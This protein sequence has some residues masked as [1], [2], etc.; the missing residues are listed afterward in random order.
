MHDKASVRA[1]THGQPVW[2]GV[3]HGQKFEVEGTDTAT[4]A[5]GDFDDR[6]MLAVL[7]KFGPDERQGQL[8]RDDGDV[9]AFFQQVRHGA[10]VVFVAV[11]QHDAF[12]VLQAITQ[13][14]EVRQDH[15]DA[16]LVLLRE[17]QSTIDNQQF[18]LVLED[19]H[20]ATDFSQPPDGDDAKTASR[21][22]RRSRQRKGMG[23]HGAHFCA[24]GRQPTVCADT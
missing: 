7:L 3:I 23:A 18:A 24:R 4:F 11:G 17:Q 20:I 9:T 14:R 1:D 22:C 16:R 2:D 6:W 12:D 5:R 15:V 21:Q 10:D 8:G 13:N 19:G